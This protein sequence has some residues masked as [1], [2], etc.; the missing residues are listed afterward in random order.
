MR[1]P[2]ILICGA[3]P[4]GSL[5][6]ERLKEAGHDVTLMAR[7]ER[8]KQLEAHGVVIEDSKTGERNAVRVPLTESLQ[9]D[10]IFDLVIVTMRKN[11]ALEL[12]P[13]LARNER[14]PVFLFMMN[15]ASGQE[16]L[17]QK[18]GRGRVMIGFPLPGGA[19]S[20]EA[21]K[22][23]P[24]D[25]K[26]PWTL[27]IGEA[28]GSIRMRTMKVAQIL[29]MMRGYKVQIRSDM[30]A[31]LKTHVSLLIPAFVPAVYATGTD[32]DRF[33]R[34]RDARILCVRGIKEA[35]RKLQA[36]G[37]PVTPRGLRL[38]EYIPEPVLVFYLGQAVKL[39]MLKVSLEHL[40]AAPDEMAL[41]ADEFNRLTS[42][43][44]LPS[45][46][47]DQL[48]GYF[49]GTEPELADCAKNISMKWGAFAAAALAKTAV[50]AGG[51][52]LWRRSRK[53]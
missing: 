12:L 25:E 27:P 1:A 19:R 7:G 43:V 20:G 53:D 33:S 16:E 36:S 5:F 21:M 13:Q 26:H 6:A 35:L 38:L 11:H 10:D 52:Y 46:A 17:I 3:G 51:Y 14:I 30:D 31:W 39:D 40:K 44:E 23:I 15:N 50:I 32:L 18:L 28:D 22:M 45:S 29:A 41:L 48:S 8:L 37:T 47:L 42:N 24:A 34:T 9:P 2:R 4:F 49:G